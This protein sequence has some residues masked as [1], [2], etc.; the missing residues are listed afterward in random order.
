MLGWL[1]TMLAL[2]EPSAGE[3]ASGPSSPPEDT[4]PALGEDAAPD[5]PV[6]AR[7]EAARRVEP[8]YPGSAMWLGVEAVDCQMTVRVDRDG[9][10][11]GIWPSRCPEPWVQ[12]STEALSKWRWEPATRDGEPVEGSFKL[13]IRY[14]QEGPWV[15]AEDF[16]RALAVTYV[17]GPNACDL[18]VLVRSD[19]VLAAT[20][21][22]LARCMLASVEVPMPADE[23]GVCTARVYP[24]TRHRISALRFVDCPKALRKPTRA[25]LKSNFVAIRDPEEVEVTWER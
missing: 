4:V 24:G 1:C 10:P 11:Q 3:A 22:N 18:R 23:A 17:G 25:F 20:T 5:G 13:N 21:P 8:D 16:A 19:E 2:A 6:I 9:R 14:V 7:P 15:P 12:P